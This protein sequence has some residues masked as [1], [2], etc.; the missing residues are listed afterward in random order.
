MLRIQ[1][2]TAIILHVLVLFRKKLRQRSFTETTWNQSSVHG[3]MHDA[4][5]LHH[6]R[7][8]LITFT[9][10]SNQV[11]KTITRS[12]AATVEF[13]PSHEI[14]TQSRQWLLFVD[15]WAYRETNYSRVLIFFRAHFVDKKRRNIVEYLIPIWR[16][17]TPDRPTPSISNDHYW[18]TWRSDF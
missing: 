11:Y 14:A 18:L 5:Q 3:S 16:Q 2:Y 8:L 4:K 13:V 6:L 12:D 15:G 9:C 17:S 10:F 1:S 7:A